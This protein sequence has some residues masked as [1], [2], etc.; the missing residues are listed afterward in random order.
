[1]SVAASSDIHQRIPL[2]HKRLATVAHKSGRDPAAITVIAASKMQP[3][4]ML[5]TAYALGIRSFGENYVSEAVPK[6]VALG[7]LAISWHCIG[8]VQS[9][10][11]HLVATHFDWVHSIDRQKIAVRL[12]NARP[13]H[14]PPL[15]CC[16]QVDLWSASSLTK[17]CGV[18]SN[19]LADLVAVTDAQPHLRLR[20]LMVLPPVD[21]LSPR[22][23]FAQLADLMNDLR[24]SY[25]QLDTLSMGMSADWELAVAEG[26]TAIRVGSAIFGARPPITDDG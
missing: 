22:T 21:H 10:K 8:A 13:A 19:E 7:D 26:A 1:M 6:I 20:G 11:T 25:P 9:N 5:R 12:N 23:I 18:S 15:N 24:S 17:R 14:L 16:L 2:L 3:V 4:L